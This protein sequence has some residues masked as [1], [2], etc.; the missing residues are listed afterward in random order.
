MEK[1][2]EKKPLS[3]F[4]ADDH[5]A[6]RHGLKLIL[7]DEYPDIHFG[8]A[9]NGTEVLERIKNGEWDILIMD[10]NMPAKDGL[11][12]LCDL[13]DQ[14]M[15]IPVLILSMH[16]E[17]QM[18]LQVIKAGAAGF[19]SKST[20]AEELIKAIEVIR[21]GR[22]Y[23]SQK[24][25]EELVD[26]LDGQSNGKKHELLSKREYQ[27]ASLMGLGKT[28][29]EV[30]AELK[31]S[32]PTISTYRARILEKLGIKTTAQLIGYMH[33]NNLVTQAA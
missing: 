32:I 5:P 13:K 22:R 16:S 11:Q 12:T 23:I 9:S 6:M 33:R 21:F 26:N 30:A 27:T 10:I 19:I 15:R 14:G 25:A 1:Q 20:A 7:T 2:K 24:T 8:E 28:V 17:E 4:I 3:I 31:L 29:S 18:A